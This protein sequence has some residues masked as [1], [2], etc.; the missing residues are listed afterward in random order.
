MTLQSDDRAVDRKLAKQYLRRRDEEAFRELYRRHTPALYGLALRL[1][2]G[3]EAEAQDVAQETWVRACRKLADF[4]WESSLR[5]W[6]C[7]IAVNRVREVARGRGREV[8]T[9]G[10]EPVVSPRTGPVDPLD[11]E[12]AIASLPPG[13]R[14]VLVLRDI[15]GYTHKEIGQFLGID[16][17]T[18]KSQLSH[19]RRAMRGLLRPE[20]RHDERR[21]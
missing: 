13:Y 16:P 1:V 4:R 3:R 2:G 19:A 12:R 21:H 15:E 9:D 17:G 7:A 18:S 5:T 10:V 14:Q 8:A 6:L 20:E 11:L